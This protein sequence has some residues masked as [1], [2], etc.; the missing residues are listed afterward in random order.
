MKVRNIND[1]ATHQCRT[2]DFEYL[3]CPL[4]ITVWSQIVFKID[5]QVLNIEF[6]ETICLRN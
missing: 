3:Y 6:L 2:V 5:F 4:T 1:I